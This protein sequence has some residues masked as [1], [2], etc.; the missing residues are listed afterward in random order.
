MKMITLSVMTIMASC[1]IN[2][3]WAYSDDH[4]CMNGWDEDVDGECATILQEDGYL[5]KKGADE[6]Y[7]LNKEEIKDLANKCW[8]VSN[9]DIVQGDCNCPSVHLLHIMMETRGDVTYDDDKAEGM[10]WSWCTK[11]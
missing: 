4:R 1:I 2:V 7:T 3:G 5:T 9:P 10:K 11:K 8:E 6:Y